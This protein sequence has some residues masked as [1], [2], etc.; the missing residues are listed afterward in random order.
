MDHFKLSDRNYAKHYADVDD[1]KWYGAGKS[2]AIQTA[3]ELAIFLPDA[4]MNF[5]PDDG[6]TVGELIRA[7]VILYRTYHGWTGLLCENDGGAAL[8]AEYA[9]KAGLIGAGEFSDLEKAAD[10]AEMADIL[11]RALPDGELEPLREIASVADME[12]GSA[13]YDS[14][15]ALA[16]A[17]VISA[18]PDKAFKPDAA[19][20]RAQTAALIDKLVH[21][22]ERTA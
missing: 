11:R 22:E 16:A 1:T 19:A 21:P 7:A 18:G 14:V 6:V 20:T 15:R 10:R 8:Y 2:G 5:R 4:Q 13:G 9:E 12:K 3:N 17:G